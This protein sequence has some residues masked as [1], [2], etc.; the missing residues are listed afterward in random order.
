MKICVLGLT[1]TGYDDWYFLS[2]NFIFF[3]G[4]AAVLILFLTLKGGFPTI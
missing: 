4:T 3:P 2:W 1:I